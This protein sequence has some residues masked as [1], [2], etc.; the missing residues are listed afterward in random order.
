MFVSCVLM[1][2]KRCNC[3]LFCTLYPTIL[4]YVTLW[5]TCWYHCI[6][7]FFSTGK[8]TDEKV[9]VF[10]FVGYPLLNPGTAVQS[11]MVLWV[12][13]G[14]VQ[15]AIR[16]WDI[17]V[18][19]KDLCLIQLMVGG[20]DESPPSLPCFMRYCWLDCVHNQLLRLDSVQARGFPIADTVFTLT[21]LRGHGPMLSKNAA[22]KEEIW[23]ASILW[24]SKALPSL[25][26]A[27]VCTK[28]KKAR[29]ILHI[30]TLLGYLV[31]CLLRQ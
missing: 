1:L 4:Y 21:G 13:L 7:L 29:E 28:P 15:H 19:L 8:V 27:L 10:I 23:S 5:T 3:I 30:F 2:T 18:M 9:F 16:N 22:K 20:N 11:W 6:N 17:S 12:T 31:V 14:R 26:L 24:R 25:S